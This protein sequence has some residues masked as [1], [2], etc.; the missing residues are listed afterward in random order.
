MAQ[1]KESLSTEVLDSIKSKREEMSTLVMEYG[2][3][4]FKKKELTN[5]ISK[6]EQISLIMENRFDEIN[7]EMTDILKELE[8]TYSKG[9]IDL[10]EG[11][12]YYESAE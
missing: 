3:L 5:E 1:L 8:K 12:V 7:N 2:Q 6:L 11:V 9:E 4:N 10:T